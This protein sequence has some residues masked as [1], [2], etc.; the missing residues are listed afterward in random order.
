MDVSSTARDGVFP[1]QERRRRRGDD[2]VCKLSK[3]CKGDDRR[4]D[5][6]WLAE[7]LPIDQ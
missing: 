2:P 1:A 5:L 3:Q 6:G 4:H 7:L